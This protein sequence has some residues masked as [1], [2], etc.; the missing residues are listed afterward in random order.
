MS[1]NLDHNIKI[2][3]I[4]IVKYVSLYQQLFCSYTYTVW[5]CLVYSKIVEGVL[6]SSWSWGSINFNRNDPRD[7]SILAWSP[8]LILELFFQNEYEDNNYIS[9]NSHI[10]DLEYLGGCNT[11]VCVNARTE[12]TNYEHLTL[13]FVNL[14][15]C[16]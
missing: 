1:L 11:K 3:W 12:G 10:M 15:M 8:P 6:I 16:R 13:W 5:L 9:I 2:Y 7:C 4:H 14:W